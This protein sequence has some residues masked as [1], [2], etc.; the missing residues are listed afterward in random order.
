[1]EEGLEKL[2]HHKI[3][4]LIKVGDSPYEYY[5]NE[6]SPK[7]YV[8][9]QIFKASLIPPHTE[10]EAEKKEIQGIAIRYIDWLFQ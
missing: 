9:E 6:A 10:L 1:M 4:F 7:G 8:L 3:D 5:V 2:K